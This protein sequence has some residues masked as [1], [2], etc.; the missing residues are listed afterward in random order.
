MTAAVADTGVQVCVAGTGHLLTLGL[1]PVILHRRAG[2]QDLSHIYLR[3]A[4]TAMCRIRL[5]DRHTVQE[6]YFIEAVDRL[7]LSQ[8]AC[9]DLKLEPE[10]FPSP[11]PLAAALCKEV[12]D[13][14]P[15]WFT[16]VS[17]K[18]LEENV[19]CLEQQLLQQFSST[20]FNTERRPL[21]MM[22]GAPHHIHLKDS[23]KPSTCHTP[24]SIPK[25]W[26]A[27]V[28]RQLDEDVMAGILRPV[29][30]S[31]ATEWCAR[32]V[33]VPKKLGK[34]HRFVDFQKLN[35]C[36][37]RETHHMPTPFDIVSDMPPRS[38]KTVVDAHWGFHQVELDEESRQLTTFIT[39]WPRYQC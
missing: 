5:P 6:V 22:T 8:A 29:P 33:V 39:P 35:V 21:R 27:E 15:P 38:F 3:Y 25:H 17:H 4:D 23:T 7:Y 24:T 13:T 9:M 18:L 11:M 30:A 1:K 31:E 26:G 28:K 37:L 2:I 16:T 10:G 32:M 12:D 36:C 14:P 20:T 19:P 34:P